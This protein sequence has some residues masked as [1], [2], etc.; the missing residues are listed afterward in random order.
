MITNPKMPLIQP[1]RAPLDRRKTLSRAYLIEKCRQHSA[2]DH[3]HREKN[4]RRD[5]STDPPDHNREHA[6]QQRHS[7]GRAVMKSDGRRRSACV[8]VAGRGRNRHNHRRRRHFNHGIGIGLQEFALWFTAFVAEKRVRRELRS[9]RTTFGHDSSVPVILWVAKRVVECVKCAQCVR[10]LA[11]RLA[12]RPTA[13]TLLVIGDPAAGYLKPL[14]ALP[15]KRE[16]IVSR[17][18]ARLR[19]AA[20]EA[21]VILNGDFLNP[22]VV[23]SKHFRMP[24]AC[25]GSTR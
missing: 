11:K 5:P 21:D 18:R 16:I 8:A 7:H 23:D 9:T 10:R 19:E 17:D 2:E 24:R 3:P 22:H 4:R 25:A 15:P 14:A 20:A 12:I 13:L 6:R 1:R